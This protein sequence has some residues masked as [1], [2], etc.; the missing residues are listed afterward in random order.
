MII[1]DE[2][3]KYAKA[4]RF[5]DPQLKPSSAIRWPLLELSAMI[6]R[7]FTAKAFY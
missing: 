2:I 7:S 6:S 3:R 4:G 5:V 1:S